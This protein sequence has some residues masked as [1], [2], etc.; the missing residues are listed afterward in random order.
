MH[1]EKIKRAHKLGFTLLEVIVALTILIISFGIAF[2]AFN[3]TLQSWKRGNE[4]LEGFQNGDYTMRQF[5]SKINSLI[6]FKDERKRYAFRFEKN[7]IGNLP[8]DWISFVSSSSYFLHP[9]DNLGNSPHRIQLFI[10]EDEYGELGLH[11]I[12]MPALSDENDYIE[13]YNPTPYLINRHIKGMEIKIYDFDAEEW[14]DS[15]EYENSIP[16][17]IMITFYVITDNDNQ[18]EISY[19]RVFNIPVAESIKQP[20]TS[21]TILINNSQ[22][23]S[24]NSSRNNTIN[25]G[26]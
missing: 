10:Q 16:E 2:Q 9:Y 24:N 26:S 3:S 7:N 23:N 14:T 5:S 15:W 21:P 11:S 6:Y 13:K 22:N 4:V 8:V 1:L 18:E 17:R 25:V 19:S 20:L 12:S